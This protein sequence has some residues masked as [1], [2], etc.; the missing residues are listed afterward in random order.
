MV[1]KPLVVL[2]EPTQNLLQLAMLKPTTK[3][4]QKKKLIMLLTL[5]LMKKHRLM[6][7]NQK[8]KQ[9]ILLKQKLMTKKLRK[10]LPRLKKPKLMIKRLK[11]KKPKILK[12]L[13]DLYI[14]NLYIN[15]PIGSMLKKIPPMAVFFYAIYISTF[16]LLSMHRYRFHLTDALPQ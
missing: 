10:R 7:K 8:K 11:I 15:Q 9:K 16:V 13:N 2:V 1:L 14:Q 12:K 6:I 5:K 4:N 3:Q